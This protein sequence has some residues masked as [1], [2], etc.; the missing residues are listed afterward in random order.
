MR[1]FKTLAV[2]AILALTAQAVASTPA[3]HAQD[4]KLIRIASQSPLSGGQSVPGTAI[5]NGTRLAVDQ[6]KKPLEDMGFK[7]EYV[8]YDDQANPDVGVSNAQNII[9]DAAIL[10][11]IGHYNSGVAIPSSAVYDKSNLVMVSPANTNVKVTDRGLKTVNRV[12]GRDDSQGAAG[13]AYAAKQLNVK[14][15]YI[16]SDKTA[17]G[18][19]VAQAFNDAIQAAGVKVLGFDKTTEKANFDSILTPIQSQNP[20]LIYFGGIYDQGS[21]FF[22]QARDKGIKAQFM[23]PDGFDASDTVK[24]GGDATVGLI[25][26]S[27]AGPASVF[28]DAKQFISDY[29]T[30]FKINPEPYAAESYAATNIVLSAITDLAKQNGGKVP[31]RA[32]VAAAV[33]ATK[34][35]KTIVGP[36]SFDANGDRTIATYYVLKVKSSDPTKWGDNDIVFQSTAASP[37][38]AKMAATMAPTMAATMAATKSQ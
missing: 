37:L 2:A 12:C 23:G 13:A 21:V 36:I 16:V 10:A 26:T 7:V 38:V 35:F 15:V 31:A 18:D 6:L 22:K 19:G 11:V 1:L 33:R 29:K 3:A 24:I 25:Y 5:S 14:T 28:P 4:A 8:P 34:D 20:D 17:Y 27:T 30:T 32:D 9:N